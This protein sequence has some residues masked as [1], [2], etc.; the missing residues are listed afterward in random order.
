MGE[1]GS[2]FIRKF[3]HPEY[4]CAYRAPK[5]AQTSRKR[6]TKLVEQ[7]SSPHESYNGGED[8]DF[9]ANFRYS[10]EPQAGGSANWI[11]NLRYIF[12]NLFKQTFLRI[13]VFVTFL[14]SFQ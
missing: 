11:D 2:D 5:R 10:L 14:Q 9:Y 1:G 4:F 8:I 7:Y 6:A 12:K 13:M 3:Y